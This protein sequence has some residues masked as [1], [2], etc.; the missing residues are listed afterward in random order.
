M[1]AALLT[2]LS[3][4]IQEKVWTL[5]Q[6]AGRSADDIRQEMADLVATMNRQ[7]QEI[8]VT[9]RQHQ[10]V[11]NDLT[12]ALLGAQ[13]DVRAL[14][15]L[16]GALPS[17]VEAFRD[18]IT[19]ITFEVI[20]NLSLAVTAQTAQI[21]DNTAHMKALDGM[22]SSVADK[23]QTFVFYY[24]KLLLMLAGTVI[25]GA[26][27]GWKWFGISL[28]LIAIYI[29][30]SQSPAI[31][32]G[33]ALACSYTAQQLREA[34]IFLTVILIGFVTIAIIIYLARKFRLRDQDD[35]DDSDMEDMLKLPISNI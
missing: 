12:V 16:L 1:A 27:C 34:V 7:Q 21:N 2:C 28:L 4:A 32:D 3:D 25:M 10:A 13:T 14:V 15:Q 5:V 33:Y 24:L 6:D 35:D 31:V 26:S 22:V 17:T 30:A 9:Q 19:T 11:S 23:I 29:W 8:A 18:D 20:S